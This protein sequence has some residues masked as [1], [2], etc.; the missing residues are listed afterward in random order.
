MAWQLIYTSAPRLLEA[1]R[2]GFGTVARHRA[3][4]GFLAT[5]IER[6][7]QFARLPGHDP[8]RVVH[9][10]RMITVGSGQFHV[11][12]CL[13]DAGS[14]Y[15]GR[16]NHIAHHLIAESGE[17]PALVAA[18]L[19]PADILLEMSWCASW[20]DRPRFFNPEE[21][22]DLRSMS[23]RPSCAWERLTGNAEFARLP[24]S[25]TARRG[26]YLIIPAGV[27]ARELF[28]ES[29]REIMVQ[30][31][32]I[33]FTTSLEPSDDVADF[34]W[35]GLSPASPLRSLAESSMRPVLDLLQPASLSAP[36]S[37]STRP[38]AEPV[39][40]AEIPPP[41]VLPQEQGQS[42]PNPFSD[43]PR[44]QAAPRR[45]REENT[46][47]EP[48]AVPSLQQQPP[49]EVRQKKRL[50]ALTLLVIGGLLAAV[51]AVAFH[52]LNQGHAQPSRTSLEQR[53][54]GI[55]NKNRLKL[56]DT[57]RWLRQEAHGADDAADLVSSHEQC[58]EQIRQSLLKPQSGRVV[59][60]PD[61]TQDDFSDLLNAHAE[62]LKRRSSARMPPNWRMQTPA[63]AQP[64]AERWKAEK[65]AWRR[66][67]DCFTQEPT[68][69]QTDHRQFVEH[70]LNTLQSD[71]QPEGTPQQWHTLVKEVVPN[72]VPGWLQLWSQLES[73]SNTAPAES[74]KTLMQQ[75]EKHPDA[76][77][78][79]KSRLRDKVQTL[80]EAPVENKRQEPMKSAVEALPTASPSLDADLPD[81]LH[82]IFV[83]AVKEAVVSGQVLG[84]LPA[85]PVEPVMS[86]QFGDVTTRSADLGDTWKLLGNAYRQA[87]SSSEKIQFEDS[88]LSHL[89]ECKNGCR[90]VARSEDGRRVLFDLRVITPSSQ[91]SELL[92]FAKA[93]EFQMLTS[94]KVARLDG[95]SRIIKRLHLIDAP[96]PQFQLRSE[97]QDGSASEQRFYSLKMD[98][99]H[100][101][102]LSRVL[103]GSEVLEIRR[104]Q[105]S[106][107]EL[108]EGIKQ[109]RKFIRN[110]N[111]RLAS[112]TKKEA[113][114]SASIADKE[115][116]L[117]EIRLR[118]QTLGEQ[119]AP[120][121][122][123]APGAYTLLELTGAVRSICR[124]QITS[125]HP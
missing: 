44:R 3:V 76:P 95:I 111:P 100:F 80:R 48:P 50:S 104:L 17:I 112:S 120:G 61:R 21:E 90:M 39:H 11:L 77:V 82:P 64:L 94:D 117:A 65:L 52:K 93:P 66:L 16:T 89:P 123:P 69:D 25:P 23:P 86:L 119:A 47:S 26:C 30:A 14:D 5:T 107:A 49:C 79:L 2:T 67:A 91:A 101:A 60:A 121:S 45:T 24:W 22:V 9:S 125:S 32:E 34:R 97:P 99:E 114:L 74:L 118:L 75:L 63:D 35:I 78:W 4:S 113:E 122:R 109:D 102:V 73:L 56:D 1:G 41:E 33:P 31:W 84:R 71:T 27:D 19:T 81:A 59:S 103:S 37:L 13:R 96:A 38:V 12:S 57:R 83:V 72:K 15:T 18:G 87:L 6:F 42:A 36:G 53:I 70:V 46:Q 7:S 55:W 62:W 28:G 68:V 115:I 85:L 43:L 51:A 116:K 110:L 92:A 54:D 106:G 8:Q 10:H 20:T 29:L 98:E 88:R 105:A 108:G 124:I 40:A 58:L